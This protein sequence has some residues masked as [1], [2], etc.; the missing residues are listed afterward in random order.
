M[1]RGVR[2]AAGGGDDDGGI[3]E[4][5]ARA[6]VARADAARQKAHDRLA[7]LERVGV[8]ALE[9]CRCAGRARQRETDGLRHAGHGVGGELAAARTGGRAGDALELVQFRV[10]HAPGRM[11]ADAF[12]HVD[13]GYVAPL[14]LAGQDRAAVEKYGG[15]VE[16]QHGHHDAGQRLVAA[17]DAD[18]CIVAVAAHRQLDG[19]G[20]DLARDERR[21]HALM[22][23]GDAVGHGDGAEFTRRAAG[24]IDAQ[25]GGL[26]LAH[27]RDVAGCCLVPARHHADERA[28]YVLLFE[29]HGVVVGAMRR[30]RRPLRHVT[31]RQL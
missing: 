17:G 13:D 5:F 7:A 22:T 11:H 28:M 19:V 29:A 21:L 20:D 15:H 26:S 27:Q 3:L 14:E 2:R 23:H 8:A 18:Q 30:A 12:E 9:R 25:L 24:F 4:G 31:A 10:R 1:Q 6:D 16:A